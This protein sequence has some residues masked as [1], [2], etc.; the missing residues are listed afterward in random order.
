MIEAEADKLPHVQSAIHYAEQAIGGE[1]PVC[2]YTRAACER[3]LADLVRSD[4]PW[5]LDELRV[6]RACEFIEGLPHIKGEWAKRRERLH[7]EP[8]QCFIIC[9]IFGFVDEEG[10]RRFSTA[11]I[12][13]ARKNAK[14][15]LAAAVGLYMLSQDFEVGAEVYSA[16]TTRNQ[17]KI[18][19]DVARAMARRT[20]DCGMR[21]MAHS[22]IDDDTDSLFEALHAQGETLDGKNIH[23][24]IN[25]ELHAWTK[26]DVYDVIET[27]CGSR[28]QALM[29]NITTA[30]NN[31]AGIC[32]D[33]RVYLSEILRHKVEDERFFGLIYTLDK[34]DD[35]MDR[36]VWIKANPNLGVS[37]YPMELE[38]QARKA[39]EIVGQ[40]NAFLTKRMNVWTSS[41]V[42]WMNMLEWAECIDQNL[43]IDDFSRERCWA[44]LDMASKIDITSS[45]QLFRRRIG[46]EDH[47]YAFM[48]HWLP[49]QAVIDDP[50]GHYDGWVRSGHIRTTPGNIIDTDQIE[51]DIMTEI[52]APFELVE[53][54]VDPMHNSTQVSVHL[55]QQGVMTIDVRPLVLNFSEAMKWL[56]A[57]VKGRRFHTNCPV[58]TWMIGNVE[59]KADYKDN[60]YPRKAGGQQNRKIDGVIAL[61]MAINRCMAG[62]ERY[63]PGEGVVVL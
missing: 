31:T 22:I 52:V 7:L 41:A 51:N 11:Y 43:N 45:A 63:F 29:F 8:W 62:E 44:G 15:T 28:K 26:R 55:A 58:L 18:V 38:S 53:M 39:A 20:P 27:A 33:L 12:E 54:A 57:L 37:V 42:G 25:D 5:M 35:W 46:N 50:T 2:E 3:F 36:D 59:V 34:D 47:Y 13:V 32:W 9:N 40:Q 17:A 19:F 49:E 48:R 21:V 1:I 6:E 60:I 56:E 16:A 24:A 4:W 10:F 23:C 14:S 61:L 30:G